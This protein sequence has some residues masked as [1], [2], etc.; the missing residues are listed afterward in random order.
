MAGSTRSVDSV[1][2]HIGITQRCVMATAME[3]ECP[4]RGMQATSLPERRFPRS[5]VKVGLTTAIAGLGWVSW[6]PIPEAV[7]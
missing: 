4:A 1:V 5:E 2:A 6:D 7:P 3:R